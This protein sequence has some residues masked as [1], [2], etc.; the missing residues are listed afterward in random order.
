M[1]QHS[2]QRPQYSRE[3]VLDRR[4]LDVEPDDYDRRV[5]DVEPDD[6][7]RRILDIDNLDVLLLHESERVASG[8]P[9]SQGAG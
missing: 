8:R 4:I 6:Y 9:R 1:L 3:R 7:A 2:R 5:L